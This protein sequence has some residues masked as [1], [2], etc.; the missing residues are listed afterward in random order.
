M[1]TPLTLLRVHEPTVEEAY[2]EIINASS[3]LQANPSALA[4]PASV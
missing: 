4:E 2:I 3:G 1:A